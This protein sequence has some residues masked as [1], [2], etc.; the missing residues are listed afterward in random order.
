MVQRNRCGFA[1]MVS[2][3]NP[4]DVWVPL[5][6]CFEIFDNRYIV[7]RSWLYL[8]LDLATKC[9]VAQVTSFELFQDDLCAT[10]IAHV[11]EADWEL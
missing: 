10:R 2:L 9:E 4:M 5:A 11:H 3:A 6:A 1:A 8:C 7:E